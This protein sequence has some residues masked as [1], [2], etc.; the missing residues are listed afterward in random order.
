MNSGVVV[1]QTTVN[2]DRVWVNIWG[3]D[4][5]DSFG[6]PILLNL[7]KSTVYF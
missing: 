6:F 1:G 7:K 5:K 4:T 3:I 2:R